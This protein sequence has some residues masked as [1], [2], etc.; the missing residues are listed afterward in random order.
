LS[1]YDAIQR[2]VLVKA[3]ARSFFDFTRRKDEQRSRRRAFLAFLR[4]PDEPQ[5]NAATRRCTAYF[6]GGG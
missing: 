2:E 5:M 6:C 3:L 4:S 1:N